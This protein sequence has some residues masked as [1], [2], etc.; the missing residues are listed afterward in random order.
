MFQDV[1][2][3]LFELEARKVETAP[4]ED[5][6]REKQFHTPPSKRFAGLLSLFRVVVYASLAVIIVLYAWGMVLRLAAVGRRHTAE[7]MVR[8]AQTAAAES[9][10]LKDMVRQLEMA[11]DMDP[12][13]P[14]PYYKLVDVY[15]EMGEYEVSFCYQRLGDFAK[16][17]DQEKSK[18]L[19]LVM[20]TVKSLV[21][22]EVKQQTGALAGGAR[23]CLPD[24]R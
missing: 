19:V 21:K 1:A 10:Q 9:G 6:T 8:R 3:Q 2:S 5:K 24:R 20:D 4:K 11:I 7:E 18:V 12:D 17:R 23:A 13:Y 14:E 22:K 15:L 16:E